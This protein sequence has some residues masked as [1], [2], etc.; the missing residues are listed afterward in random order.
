MCGRSHDG[1]LRDVSDG[2]HVLSDVVKTVG[3]TC[4]AVRLLWVEL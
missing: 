4:V 1:F 3:Y 2:N